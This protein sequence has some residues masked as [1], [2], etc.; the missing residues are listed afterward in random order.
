MSCLSR[1]ESS[2]ISHQSIVIRHKHKYYLPLTVYHLSS[3]IFRLSSIISLLT[4]PLYTKNN[5]N[6][7]L[8]VSGKTRLMKLAGIIL[9]LLLA[10]LITTAAKSQTYK[11]AVGIR[12]STSPAAVNNSISLKYFFT[13]ST[14][15]E[16][17]LSF[18]DP[19]AVGLLIEKHKPLFSSSFTYFY[20]A[21]AYAS[22]AGTR[23]F[24]G[25]G[26]IGLDYKTPTLPLNFSIDWKPELN[27]SKEFSFEPAALG[28]SARFTFK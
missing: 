7:H 3:I 15:A 26:V 9:L 16:A 17:L 11:T 6:L 22:F 24:G 5:L 2:V 19:L 14:A 21:G 1:F 12:F 8:S 20:G 28:L 18:G 10:M 13:Q 25:Q 27:F 4:F 23:N